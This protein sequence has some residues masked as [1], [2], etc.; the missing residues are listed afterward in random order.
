MTYEEAVATMEKVR[1]M[2]KKQG[3]ADEEYPQNIKI[4]NRGSADAE[5]RRRDETGK[6]T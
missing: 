3:W 1:E 6:T 5:E 4:Q 2:L